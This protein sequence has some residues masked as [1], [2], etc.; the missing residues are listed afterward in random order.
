MTL[1]ERD[2]DFWDNLEQDLSVET[3]RMFEDAE[4]DIDDSIDIWSSRYWTKVNAIIL[5]CKIVG[6]RWNHSCFKNLERL[7]VAEYKR[8]VLRALNKEKS[9]IQQ[10]DQHFVTS[11]QAADDFFRENIS[12]EYLVRRRDV[13]RGRLVSSWRLEK[14]DLLDKFLEEKFKTDQSLLRDVESLSYEDFCIGG[15]SHHTRCLP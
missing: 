1:L 4:Q 2:A 8:G 12:D 7:C 6:R 15:R 5:R 10:R 11:I 3:E 14:R 9:Y 13:L